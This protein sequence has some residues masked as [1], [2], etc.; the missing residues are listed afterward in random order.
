M[1]TKRRHKLLRW[2]SEHIPYTQNN[3]HDTDPNDSPTMVRLLWNAVSLMNTQ[4]QKFTASRE[5][6]KIITIIIIITS[7]YTY[8]HITYIYKHTNRVAKHRLSSQH[9]ANSRTEV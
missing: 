7:P 6:S 8:I 5:F 9:L 2:E 4:T 1:R 3:S